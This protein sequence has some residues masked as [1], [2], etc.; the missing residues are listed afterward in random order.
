MIGA[1]LVQARYLNVLGALWKDDG[2]VVVRR[3]GRCQGH[4]KR[5]I[6]GH[7]AVVVPV[8]LV[9][10]GQGVDL[11]V[12]VVIKHAVALGAP[13]QLDGQTRVG[14]DVRGRDVGR[15]RDDVLALRDERAR[16]AVAL[17]VAVDDVASFRVPEDGGLLPVS[18]C[19]CRRCPQ[20]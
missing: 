19:S 9:G 15:L 14:V 2:D 4:A 18:R 20:Y 10:V 5:G 8:D 1:V 13:Q 16:L 11:A 12:L 17:V 6:L 3:M 7:G